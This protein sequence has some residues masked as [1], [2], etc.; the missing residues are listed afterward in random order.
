MGNMDLIPE[1]YR[2]DMGLRRMVRNFIV[3]C[4]VVVCGIGLAKA[5]FTYLIWREN[6]HVVRLE[7][8][9]QVSQQNKSKTEEYRQQK[10]VTEQQ[11]AALTELHGNDR[12][13]LFLHAIDNAYTEGV[14][15]DSLRFMRRSSTGTL[16]NV[17]GAANAGIIVAPDNAETPQSLEVNHGAEIIGHAINHSVLAEFMRKLGTET[18]VADLRLIDTGTRSYTT[19]QVVDFKLGLQMNEQLNAQNGEN[20]QVAP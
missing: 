19:M 14:W 1:D 8:Q 17:P 20:A 4:L 12:V 2:Q 5:A 18:S 13:T 7:Q 16:D 11:L 6:A 10:Q 15:F 9:E 3:A